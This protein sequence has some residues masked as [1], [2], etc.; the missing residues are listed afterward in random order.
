VHRTLTVYTTEQA[1]DWLFHFAPGVGYAGYVPL[2]GGPGYHGF[3]AELSF[4]ARRGALPDARRCVEASA[5]PSCG[6]SHV[7]FYAAME[8]T[9][10]TRDGA[11]PLGAYALGFT[12]SFERHAAR[13][14]LVPHYALEVGVI[15]SDSLPL[16]FEAMPALG[17]HVVTA[18]P[19]WLD[20]TLGLRV[21][22]SRL[23]AMLGPHAGLSLT[24]D[25]F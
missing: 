3:R 20:A 11:A 22:P 7:R 13:T 15:T 6:P 24:L 12:R 9:Y 4:A 1:R 21:V 10:A 25:A 17:L 19:F 23:E 8:V 16:L 5:G 14:F 2:G 18:R